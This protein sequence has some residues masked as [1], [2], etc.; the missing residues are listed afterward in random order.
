METTKQKSDAIFRDVIELAIAAN[1][2]LYMAGLVSDVET[3]NISKRIK[4]LE[5]RCESAKKEKV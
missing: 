3:A 1:T 2:H 4:K 5:E